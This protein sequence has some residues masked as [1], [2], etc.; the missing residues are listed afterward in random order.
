MR[1]KIL[2]GTLEFCNICMVP[3][4]LDETYW[5]CLQTGGLPSSKLS[6]YNYPDAMDLPVM[7]HVSRAACRAVLATN[8]PSEIKGIKLSLLHG[9]TISIKSANF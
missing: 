4:I 7:L 1:G 5:L 8:C 2:P 6:V 3:Q 9:I